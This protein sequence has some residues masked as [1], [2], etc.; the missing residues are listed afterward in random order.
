MLF[1]SY[2]IP[3]Q[4]ITSTN[5]RYC[6]STADPLLHNALANTLGNTGGCICYSFFFFFLPF[7]T[8][9]LPF[10]VTRKETKISEMHWKALSASTPHIVPRWSKKQTAMRETEHC[11]VWEKGKWWL[12]RCQRCLR[13]LLDRFAGEQEIKRGL[14]VLESVDNLRRDKAIGLSWGREGIPSEASVINKAAQC[15]ISADRHSSE[16]AET[17][18]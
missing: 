4:L 15:L 18:F 11:G 1:Y 6:T 12:L 10:P 16:S 13:L 3:E 7:I 5:Q 17:S 8:L 14:A 2:F 9:L